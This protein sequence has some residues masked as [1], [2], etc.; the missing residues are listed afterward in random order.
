MNFTGRR[1]FNNM[2]VEK[3]KA[4]TGKI[5]SNQVYDPTNIKMS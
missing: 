1:I 5:D 3:N 2:Y 4:I